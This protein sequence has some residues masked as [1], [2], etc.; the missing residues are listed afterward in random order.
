[1]FNKIIYLK[2][3]QKYLY[4]V[5]FHEKKKKIYFYVRPID[6]EAQLYQA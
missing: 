1:M 3:L 4:F 5:H 6:L 2:I